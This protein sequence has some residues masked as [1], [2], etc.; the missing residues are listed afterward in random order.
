VDPGFAH[1]VQNEE[2]FREFLYE[3]RSGAKVF[4]IKQQVIREIEPIQLR[5]AVH[6]LGTQHELIVGFVPDNM[7]NL[8]KLRMSRKGLQL[9]LHI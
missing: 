4:G 9:P 2:L 6:K 5:Y 7:T 3:L 1:V 8:L